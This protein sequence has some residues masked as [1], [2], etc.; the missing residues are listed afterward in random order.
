[1]AN[2]LLRAHSALAT[3]G[4]LNRLLERF[5]E[6]F[7]EGPNGVS[8]RRE[9][10]DLVFAGLIRCRFGDGRA[11]SGVGDGDDHAWEKYC[12]VLCRDRAVEL[13]RRGWRWASLR[14]ERARQRC[15]EQRRDEKQSEER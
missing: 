9:V 5:G 7:E 13:G 8:A 10:R 15:A 14:G 3:G 1:L 4:G 2:A 11:R 12:A 6:S